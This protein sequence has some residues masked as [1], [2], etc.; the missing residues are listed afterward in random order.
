MVAAAGEIARLEIPDGPGGPAPGRFAGLRRRLALLR[1][2]VPVAD[3]VRARRMLAASA[4]SRVASHGDF[5]S[6]NVLIAGG[7]CWVIDWELAG[8]R[9]AGYDLMRYWTGAEEEEREVLFEGAVELAG[10]SATRELLR[11]R[12]AV[13]VQTIAGMLAAV[14]DFDRD[15]DRGQALLRLLP[16]LRREAGV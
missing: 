14:N 12:Y 15:P 9:P 5:H 1:S 11:L 16:E 13:T 10:P 3:L 6:N 8:R 4:L 7:S 2:K